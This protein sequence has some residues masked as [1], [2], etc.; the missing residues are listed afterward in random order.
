MSDNSFSKSFR[1]L[2][3]SDFEYLR[4]GCNHINTPW[5][6]AYYKVSKFGF[7]ETRI[8]FSVSKKVGKA[9][10][11][12]RFK[13]I[14][15]EIFRKSDY[16]FL[17]KDVL[18]VVSREVVKKNRGTKGAETVLKPSFLKILKILSKTKAIK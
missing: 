11:R 4:K 5:I 3:A 1:L 18:F 16:K 14:L 8:G 17:G 15:K 12:N 6:K 2:S 9:N 13:R 7:P 10:T